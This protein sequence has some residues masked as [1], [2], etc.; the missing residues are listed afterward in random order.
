M[1]S[2]LP[3]IVWFVGSMIVA[4]LL[5]TFIPDIALFL[6]RLLAQ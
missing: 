5:V 1:E 2:T 6:P 4:L 3:W